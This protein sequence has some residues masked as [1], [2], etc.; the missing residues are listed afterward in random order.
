MKVLLKVHRG[1]ETCRLYRLDHETVKESFP[2]TGKFLEQF[3]T[4]QL[5]KMLL[6]CR[7]RAPGRKKNEFRIEKLSVYLSILSIKGINFFFVATRA[8]LT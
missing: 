7:N 5:A 6:S 1:T 2:F 3:Q 4:R 8:T